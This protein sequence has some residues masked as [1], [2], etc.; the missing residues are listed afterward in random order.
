MIK[1]YFK[2]VGAALMLLL[3]I[4]TFYILSNN[5]VYALKP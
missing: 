5:L 1:Q 4:G 3:V 2:I